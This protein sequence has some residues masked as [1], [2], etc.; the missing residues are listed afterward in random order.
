M[1]NLI[2]AMDENWLVGKDNKLPWRI[3]EDLKHFKRITYNKNV[4]MGHCTYL[5]M[6]DYYGNRPFPFK[7]IYVANLDD[8][9]YN[10]AVRVRDVNVFLDR[11][12]KEVFVIGGSTIYGIAL[13]YANNLYIT[14][15]LDN[16]VGDT[17]FPNFDLSKFRLVDYKTS[18]KMIVTK[19]ERKK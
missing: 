15:I 14:F 10:D 12:K 2:W 5:S 4:L 19:Y 16:Y 6:K 8:Y 17:Y 9:H 7:D 1:I 13:P 11:Y 18:D 3:E